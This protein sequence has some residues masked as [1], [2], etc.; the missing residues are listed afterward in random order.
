MQ[1]YFLNQI[2]QT[3]IT[4]EDDT[5][6]YVKIKNL[7]CNKRHEIQMK[8]QATNQEKIFATHMTNIVSIKNN[9]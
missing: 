7:F 6:D 1:N 9:R 2:Q 3:L 4:E 8:R 5:F